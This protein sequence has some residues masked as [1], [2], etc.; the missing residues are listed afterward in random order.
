MTKHFHFDKNK[1]MKANEEEN[2]EKHLYSTCTC[3]LDDRTTTTTK[4]I[5]CRCIKFS[6]IFCIQSF[7]TIK[8]FSATLFYTIL[9]VCVTEHQN[10]HQNELYFPFSF[11]LSHDSFI[12]FLFCFL[13]ECFHLTWT[14]ITIECFTCHGALNRQVTSNRNNKKK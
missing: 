1:G 13:I 8:P 6:L 9:Y 14:T 3:L 10:R 7:V 4:K 12:H 11:T 5:K 2:W